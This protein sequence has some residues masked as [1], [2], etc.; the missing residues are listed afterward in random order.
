MFPKV[1]DV[2]ETI[3]SWAV[4]A[5]AVSW[6]LVSRPLTFWSY[7]RRR[8]ADG[9]LTLPSFGT[10]ASSVLVLDVVMA[11]SMGQF[12]SPAYGTPKAFID[13]VTAQWPF[14][15][16]IVAA[17]ATSASI[18]GLLRFAFRIPADERKSTDR[19]GTYPASIAL[20]LYAIIV[21]LDAETILLLS[22]FLVMVFLN[23]ALL[24]GVGRDCVWPS[25]PSRVVA[26]CS[27]L[28]LA[29]LVPLLLPLFVLATTE[30]R[31]AAPKLWI[32][33]S[34]DNF[35]ITVR[36]YFRGGLTCATRPG[37][38]S[39][40]SARTHPLGCDHGTSSAGLDM[41]STSAHA[42]RCRCG[43]VRQTFRCS[44]SNQTGR[45]GSSGT[46]RRYYLAGHASHPGLMFFSSSRSTASRNFLRRHPPR[47]PTSRSACR[48]QSPASE[49]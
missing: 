29:P 8:G 21:L 9:S 5:A 18:S 28:L 40:F 15:I 16:H 26:A 46:S 17:V 25:D 34:L 12:A 24:V 38:T 45:F 49:S 22:P 47:S 19:L 31:Q 13:D 6:Q 42:S 10:L 44:Q 37:K 11:V 39:S 41:G 48:T 33:V 27:L 14:I 2:A 7:I 23:V 30:A 3:R 36:G 35:E 32:E 1:D 20:L 43:A 4:Q